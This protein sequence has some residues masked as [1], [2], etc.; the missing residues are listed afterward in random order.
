MKTGM[1]SARQFGCLVNGHV[2]FLVWL[3]MMTALPLVSSPAALV[4]DFHAFRTPA[5]GTTTHA[6]L[7]TAPA[8]LPRSYALSPS[9]TLS[10]PPSYD[11]QLG[12]SFT[13]TFT[14]L[15]YN[16]TAVAQ[17]DS[18]GYGPAYLLNGLTDKGYWYQVG[19]SWNWPSSGNSYNPGFNL[20]YEVFDPSGNSVFPSDGGGGLSSFNGPVNQG[21]TVL[22]NLYFT[23]NGKVE[24]LASDQNT[25]AQASETYSAQGATYFVGTPSAT[26]DA[27]GFF[28]GLM[29]EWWH[30]DPYYGDEQKVTYSVYNSSISSAWMWIE[31]W[32]PQTNQT[33][34]SASTSV[35]FSNPT[36]LQTFSSH[37]ATESSNAYEFITGSLSIV[38]LTLSYSVQGGGSGYL[39]PTLTYILNGSQQTATLSTFPATYYIDAGTF[40]SVT[41][42][43]GNSSP[44]ERWQ[45]DQQTSGNASSSQTI[46]I[47]YYHQYFVIVQPIPSGGG[48]TSPGSNWFDANASL[49]IAAFPSPSWQ[50]EGWNGTGAGSYSGQTNTTWVN[51]GSAMTER[52]IFYPG[53]TIETSIGIA[54]LYEYGST[55]GL[56]LSGVSHTIYA[57]LGTNIVL[58]ATPSFFIYAF[59]GWSG[60]VTSSATTIS[61]TLNTHFI[62]SAN[63]SYNYM[64]IALII[65]A[66]MMCIAIIMLTIILRKEQAKIYGH[67][68]L[69]ETTNILVMRVDV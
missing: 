13:Q 22:L 68:G 54:I 8:L 11:E 1:L 62:L 4:A 40:W 60:A 36:Q 3:I 56:I 17:T 16:V 38:A 24:M 25:G 20:N 61:V 64:N 59:S 46:N 10:D 5:A 37:G 66:G 18:N 29:T 30:T 42:P 35:T 14:A 9:S 31:E 34:F 39:A 43:L 55:M 44:T 33:L 57:P 6:S 45:T 12:L 58:T 26:A 19:L 23:A 49:R 21:D 52:A 65:T 2:L 53:L 27:P 63:H 48:L 7:A 15:A 47:V 67:I 41:N 28:T 32:N 69:L 50:F 51:I